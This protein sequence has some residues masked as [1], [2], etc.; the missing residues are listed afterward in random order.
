[1]CIIEKYQLTGYNFVVLFKKNNTVYN[2]N[3]KSKSSFKSNIYLRAFIL[4][5]IPVFT[6]EKYKLIVTR[7]VS[8][9]C[10][11]TSVPDHMIDY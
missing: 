1:M 10:L 4:F 2:I 5:I 9:M 7:C 11:R 6:C 8:S 3:F